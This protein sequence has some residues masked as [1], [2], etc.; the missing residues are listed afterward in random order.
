[1]QPTTPRP[2]ALI[3]GGSSGIGLACA[4]LAV[5]RGVSVILASRT[6]ARLA[7]AQRLL[8]EH[9]AKG[10]VVDVC[11]VDL[12][13]WGDFTKSLIARIQNMPDD[14]NI[15]HLINAA[16]IFAPK[17]FV[18]CTEEDYDVS[19]PEPPAPTS[20]FPR[21][22]TIL[23][24]SS[25][26]TLCFSRAVVPSPQSR[27][28]LRHT[29]R[30]QAHDLARG[31][32][33][34]RQHW[35]HVGQAEHQGHAELGLL[36]GQGRAALPHPDPRPRA[37]RPSHPRQRRRPGRRAYSHLQGL[38]RRGQGRGYHALPRLHASHRQGRRARGRRQCRRLFIG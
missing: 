33:Q 4:R 30:R 20:L 8:Q 27:H 19:P 16:G 18:D 34:H 35:L 32:R 37:R 11:V 3:I 36:H 24:I 10:V 7:D 6:E 28:L 9:A 14:A 5:R 29:S 17:P 38:H 2:T 15:V 25:P 13:N 23:T 22:A 31:G 21:Y 12:A 26:P 1:M